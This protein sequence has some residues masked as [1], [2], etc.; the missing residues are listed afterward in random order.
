MAT[1][2]QVKTYLAYWFQLG[3]KVVIQGGQEAV[4]PQPVIAGNRYSDQFEACWNYLQSSESGDCYLEGTAQTIT[5]LLSDQCEVSDCARCAMPV[6]ILSVGINALEC[7][8]IDLP[9]WPNTELPQPRAPVDTT[10][11]LSQIRERL[12]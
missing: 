10:A 5:E 8:C 12:T 9:T 7:P 6:P 2:N 11:R 3:K 4:L 1:S